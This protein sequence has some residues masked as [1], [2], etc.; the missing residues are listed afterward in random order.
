M[1]RI[2]PD[3]YSILRVQQNASDKEIK[4]AYR[5]IA[6]EFHP[7]LNPGNK[8]AEQKLQ[9][10][11]EAYATLKDPALRAHYNVFDYPL[12]QQN[13]SHSSNKKYESPGASHN[14]KY[15]YEDFQ[16]SAPPKNEPKAARDIPT[17][18]PAAR[19]F[20]HLG[21]P[22]QYARSPFDD[23]TRPSVKHRPPK[24]TFG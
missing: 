14:E 23:I 15:S 4:S 12:S 10:A 24:V 7:D 16:K 13:V 22:L 5:A 1:P 18:S 9:S 17:D 2:K 19:L 20:T 8:E 21:V 3:F 6:R 11:G